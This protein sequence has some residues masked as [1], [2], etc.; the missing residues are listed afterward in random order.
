[1]DPNLLI[2]LALG[3]LNAI[4]G[5]IAQIRSQGGVSDDA[6]AL[7][8]QTITKANDDLYASMMGALQITPPTPPAPAAKKV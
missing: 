6:I 2:Q 5:V 8:V 3:A 1:M 7:Q 4:L